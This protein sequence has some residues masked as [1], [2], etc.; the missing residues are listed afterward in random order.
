MA[1]GQTA[2]AARDAGPPPA[3]CRTTLNY[4]APQAATGEDVGPTEVEILDGRAAALPGWQ[5]CGF[6]LMTHRASATDWDDEAHVADAHYPEME[7]LA[8]R[9]TGCDHAL[10]VSHITRNP[11]QASRHADLGPI[12]FVH[13]DFAASYGPLLRR[14][15]RD[16]REETRRALAR[17]GIDGDVVSNAR[18]LVVLQF[19]R[20]VGAP[21]MDLPI[22]FCDARTVPATDLRILPVTDYAGGGFDFETLAVAAPEDPSRHHWYAFD[23]MSDTEI[24]AFRTYDSDMADRGGPFW[25]PHSAFADPAVTPGQPS[26]RSIE[27]RATCVFR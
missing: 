7:T 2:S 6:E 10:I 15:Y 25:T 11:E 16:P 1:N 27:L 19:W 22:A 5:A 9:L 18:R 26:R 12:S 4:V 8:S 17:A 24:V 13:S 21:K 14:N 20:N 23:S 3:L